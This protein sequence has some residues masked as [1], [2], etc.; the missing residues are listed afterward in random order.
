MNLYLISQTQNQTYDT[1]DIAVVAAESENHARAIH[2]S[3]SDEIRANMAKDCWEHYEF[4]SA[5]NRKWIRVDY[6][7]D[8]W[9]KRP[10]DVTV[11][12]IGTAVDGTSAGVICAKFNAG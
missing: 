7:S 11:L 9:T 6:F 4:V 10:S 12:L 5:K 1:Y 3:G 8:G 2:P